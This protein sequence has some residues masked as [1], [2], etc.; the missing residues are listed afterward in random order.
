MNELLTQLA[1]SGDKLS[2]TGILAALFVFTVIALY[3]EWIVLGGPYKRCMARVDEFE[4]KATAEAQANE[5]KI[6]RL[7]IQ[8]EELRQRETRRR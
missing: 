6:S 3:R 1:T 8:L 5:A 7:E 4:R 2:V